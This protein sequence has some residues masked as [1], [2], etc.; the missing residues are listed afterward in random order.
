MSDALD[1]A[2]HEL[3]VDIGRME[4][5]HTVPERIKDIIALAKSIG[6]SEGLEEAAKVCEMAE[7]VWDIDTWMEATKKQ[8]SALT[9]RSLADRI[10][11][12]G[13]LP[14]AVGGWRPIETAP[15]DGTVI[16]GYGPS[17]HHPDFNDHSSVEAWSQDGETFVGMT[18]NPVHDYWDCEP[19]E[20]THWQPLPT[21][22]VKKEDL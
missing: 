6:K 20:L 13:P 7:L 3:I 14:S 9:A 5:L 18:W 2:A 15:K 8:I 1:K 4:D 16:R 11:A 22:P 17:L 19:V 10:R 12:I 21:P